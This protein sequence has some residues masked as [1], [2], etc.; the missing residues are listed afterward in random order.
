MLGLH[1]IL[2]T[3]LFAQWMTCEYRC[4]RR[5]QAGA[6]QSSDWDRYARIVGSSVTIGKAWW[7]A[8]HV[9]WRVIGNIR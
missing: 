9:K 4:R 5:S 3:K 1:W 2:G 6:M 7:A 8:L